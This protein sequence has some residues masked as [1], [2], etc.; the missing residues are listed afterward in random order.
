[1]ALVVAL[2]CMGMLCIPGRSITE[3]KGCRASWES[4]LVSSPDRGFGIPYHVSHPRQGRENRS[5]P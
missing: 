5:P 4:L 1:M 2:G 3:G